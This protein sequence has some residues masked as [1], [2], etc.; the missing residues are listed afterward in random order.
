MIKFEASDL[1]EGGNQAVQFFMTSEEEF[2]PLKMESNGEVF[3]TQDVSNI[4][5]TLV[6]QVVVSKFS[7]SNF[8]GAMLLLAYLV[9]VFDYTQAMDAGDPPLNSTTMNVDFD[10]VDRND[11]TPVMIFP[12]ADGTPSYILEVRCTLHKFV[13]GKYGF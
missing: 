1:D 12:E 7:F 4:S 2:F 10:I 11:E 6:G 5:Q 9:T 13:D 3:L 8:L